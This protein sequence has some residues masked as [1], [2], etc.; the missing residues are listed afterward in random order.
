MRWRRKIA[1][2]FILLM[3]AAVLIT[4][5]YSILF[6]RDHLYGQRQQELLRFA[7][8][9]AEETTQPQDLCRRAARRGYRS[10]VIAADGKLQCADADLA[11]LLQQW[12][13]LPAAHDSLLLARLSL[14]QGGQWVLALDKALVLE[15]LRPIR[16]IIYHAM[17][18]TLGL[19]ALAAILLSL[20]LSRPIVRI[21]KTLEEIAQ[22]KPELLARD[23]RRKDEIGMIARA[24]NSVSQN[25][26]RDNARLRALNERQSRFYAD[27]A[28]ELNNPLHSMKG[29][30]EMLRLKGDDAAARARYLDILQNQTDRM[31]RLFQDV[32]TLQQADHTAHAV[33]P[34]PFAVAPLL[35]RVAQPYWDALAAKGLHFELQASAD[36]QAVGDPAKLEQVLDNLLSNAL[37]YC[38]QGGVQ[39]SARPVAAADGAQVELAVQDSGPGIAPEHLPH[40]TDRFYR[41]D[42]ARTRAQGGTGLG[43]AVVKSLLEA[44]GSTLD[45]QSQPGNGSRFAFRLPAA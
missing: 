29:A 45:I 4:I 43:L 21:K 11:R 27:I 13:T 17:F 41:T 26:T 12:Q 32:L 18:I 35:Q 28:H 42:A 40:L 16:W 9:T 37:K 3:A 2:I 22:G 5:G 24:L 19:V 20:A 6:I 7:K 38:Q 44:Q 1:G 10:A 39:L 36:L 30:L 15:E 14:P 34:V 8:E 23:S 25:L 33:Q 31:A